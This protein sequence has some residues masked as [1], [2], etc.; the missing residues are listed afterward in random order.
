MKRR[1][2]NG[3]V[4]LIYVS[5]IA[6]FGVLH[7]HDHKAAVGSD[8]DCAACAWQL[9]GP[10]DVPV[11]VVTTGFAT[12]PLEAVALPALVLPRAPL[13]TSTASRVPPEMA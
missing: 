5:V 10:A 9:S 3:V 2:F 6:I 8:T 13:L 7:Q 11:T 1:I 4:A 12:V